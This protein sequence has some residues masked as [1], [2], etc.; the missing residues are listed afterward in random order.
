M[1]FYKKSFIILAIYVRVFMLRYVVFVMLFHVVFFMLLYVVFVDRF[2]K[3]ICLLTFENTCYVE[4]S[5]VGFIV[6][7]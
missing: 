5:F 3:G 7:G 4:V 6:I 1:P 2:G